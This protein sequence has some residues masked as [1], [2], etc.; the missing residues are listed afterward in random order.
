MKKIKLILPL[1]LMSLA[2]PAS[3]NLV[4]EMTENILFKETFDQP[5]TS[6]FYA[7]AIKNQYIDIV[8]G[9]GK[10][11]SD[12]IRVAYVGYER[13]SHRVVS[14]HSLNKKVTQATLSFQV[15]FEQSFQW[16]LGGK[17]HGLGPERPVTGGNDRRPDGWSARIMFKE[18][19]TC[20]TY[21]YD[22]DPTKKWGGGDKTQM[23]VLK[24]G[25]WHNIVLQVSL[26]DADKS[27]GFTRVIIDGETV[28]HTKDVQ[29]RS[30][31]SP[32]TEIQKFLFS[33]F[34]GGNVP[35]WAPVDEAGNP[36]TVYALFDNFIVA[37]GIQQL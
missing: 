25:Q 23:P 6:D 16:V 10:D 29:F 4:G 35:K 34:H 19:G 30:Q 9:A 5:N 15:R 27:N 32:D 28:L 31:G 24:A 7:Q 11:G 14:W 13:G 37:E 2:A 8:K 18:E 21:L 20:A 12:A 33:T 17:L 22:Q 3:A 36:I 1:I 26:N